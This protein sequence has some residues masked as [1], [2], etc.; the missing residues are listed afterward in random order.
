MIYLCNEVNIKWC[1]IWKFIT[2][3]FT[4]AKHHQ[5]NETEDAWKVVC[6]EKHINALW[7]FHLRSQNKKIF[8]YISDVIILLLY[9][10]E[11]NAINRSFPVYSHSHAKSEHSVNK[12]LFAY[13]SD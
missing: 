5:P 4:T 11:I 12:I 9:L 7:N 8:Q 6:Y 13:I 3:L 10:C 2:Q 1:C